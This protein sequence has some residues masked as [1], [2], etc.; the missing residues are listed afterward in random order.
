MTIILGIGTDIVEIRRVRKAWE[1]TGDHFLERVFTPRE[2]D[3]CRRFSDPWP[4]LAAR[5]A[6]KESVIK[7]FGSSV[8]PLEIEIVRD[9]KGPPRVVLHG[10]AELA[11]KDMGIM[12]IK[13]SISH[14]GGLA[15]AQAIALGGNLISHSP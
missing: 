13:L 5:F 1:R 6:A 8:E 10:S 2:L 15:S 11:M 12:E 9:S 7:A 4:H 14:S 3:Y